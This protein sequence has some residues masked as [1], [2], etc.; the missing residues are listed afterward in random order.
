MITLFL[1]Q[2]NGHC[3]LDNRSD[4]ELG[5]SKLEVH[6]SG[7]SPGQLEKDLIVAVQEV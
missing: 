5:A 2:W 6:P 4:C 3:P 7:R 1:K